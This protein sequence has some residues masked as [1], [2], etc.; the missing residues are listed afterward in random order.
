MKTSAPR[1]GLLERLRGVWRRTLS[2]DD[3]PHRIAL[4]VAIGTFVAYQPIVGL[5][6]VI[7]ALVCRLIGANVIASLPM[8]WIT[9][10]LTIPP[11]FYGTYRLGAVF[12]G[13]ELT[14]A[15]IEAYF[16]DLQKLGLVDGFLEGLGLLGSIFWPMVVGG[17][18]IGVLNGGLF[19]VL[20][21]RLVTRYQARGIQ[22]H[23]AR[24]VPSP[25]K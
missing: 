17:A 13:G 16:A 24:P 14:Y 10:P 1:P 19:Y 5:Q 7:G 21:R 12:T 6:M 23:R 15:Q 25:E 8:A 20:V 3:T 11:I 9:N 22:S 2:L 18:V 4:G